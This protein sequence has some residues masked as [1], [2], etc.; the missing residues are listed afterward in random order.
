[1]L[2]DLTFEINP[3]L[4]LRLLW[5]YRII[6]LMENQICFRTFNLLSSVEAEESVNKHSLIFP[7]LLRT[8]R[9]RY[10]P[11]RIFNSLA[12][13]SLVLRLAAAYDGLLVDLH[14]GFRK[15]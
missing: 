1:M 10:C 15:S 7:R 4:A 8:Q 2:D 9:M 3:W 5:D 11:H 13:Q 6:P 14:F 12:C